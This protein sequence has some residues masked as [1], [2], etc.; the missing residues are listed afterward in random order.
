MVTFYRDRLG[1]FFKA[2]ESQTFAGDRGLHFFTVQF[3]AVVHDDCGT[4]AGEENFF[5]SILGI[6]SLTGFFGY[7]S[8]LA[9]E[10]NNV[11]RGGV[12]SS[13]LSRNRVG[14]RTVFCKRRS[15]CE[16]ESS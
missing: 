13:S 9:F 7:A 15:D 10:F 3:F 12:F 14:N 2:F 5:H 4:I 6:Q 11:D 16:A 1:Y 8:P